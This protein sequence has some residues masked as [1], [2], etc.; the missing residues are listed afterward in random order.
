MNSAEM[1]EIEYH[2]GGK[3]KKIAPGWCMRD[4]IMCHIQ[5]RFKL[6]RLLFDVFDTFAMGQDEKEIF[7][8]TDN[9]RAFLKKMINIRRSEMDSP[10]FVSKG[11]FLTMLLQDELF[12]G[13]DEYIVD[14]CLTF[15]GAA[16]QTTTIL[17][18]NA[19]YYLT[20][21]P[22]KKEILRK[23]LF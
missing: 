8:N 14:E 6:I 3:A 10:S 1:G 9:L 19:I 12:R 4:L 17:I 18:S 20:K 23:E 7:A 22:E 16:T 15:M 13:Q 5:R 11:D 2:A 21:C